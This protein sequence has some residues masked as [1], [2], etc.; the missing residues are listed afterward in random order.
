[1]SRKAPRAFTLDG[2]A[3]GKRI[4]VKVNVGESGQEREARFTTPSDKAD[5]KIATYVI[6][7]FFFSFLFALSSSILSLLVVAILEM[8][9]RPTSA[10]VA[11]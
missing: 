4:L 5:W 3:P 2:F 9:W 8:Q 7:F 10:E 6:V 1:M 11:W